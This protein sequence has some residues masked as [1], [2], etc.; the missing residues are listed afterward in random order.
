MKEQ[1][2]EIDLDTVIQ[3]FNHS[4]KSTIRS[5]F[6]FLNF[7]KRN[8]IYLLPLFILFAFLGYKLDKKSVKYSS[9]LFIQTNFNN[10][11]YLYSKIE[12]IDSKNKNKDNQ[13][14]KENNIFNKDV[15]N[16]KVKPIEDPFN[17]IVEN[18][19]KTFDL[20]KLF[21]EENNIEKVVADKKFYK[22]YKTHIITIESSQ[23]I[24]FKKTYKSILNTLNSNDYYLKNMTAKN[25]NI[26]EKINLNNDMIK[27]IDRIITET[28]NNDSKNYKDK[29]LMIGENN[30]L[31]DL[32][33]MKDDLIRENQ[34]YRIKLINNTSI[35]KVISDDIDNVKIKSNL[36][37]F[38]LPILSVLIYLFIAFLIH[39][40]RYIK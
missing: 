29:I 6:S 11:E 30:Q 1:N 19:E 33:K 5:F 17:F 39:L 2:Q 36:F 10:V 7:I 14:L 38:V 37:I 21:S 27:Q 12:A 13:Y 31:S 15:T 34:D 9:E 32:L 16:I 40:K 23:P 25:E 26:K 3:K 18:S 4:I 28:N 20:L 8:L 24:D 22:N 35:F